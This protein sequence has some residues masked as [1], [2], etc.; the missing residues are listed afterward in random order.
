[1]GRGRGV[2]S[3][4]LPAPPPKFLDTS[5]MK[6]VLHIPVTCSL[7]CLCRHVLRTAAGRLLASQVTQQEGPLPTGAVGTISPASSHM[8]WGGATRLPSVLLS[9]HYEPT[10]TESRSSQQGRAGQGRGPCASTENT[11]GTTAT[12]L[13]AALFSSLFC[14]R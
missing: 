1:M 4:S 9:P 12:G 7:R 5:L 14:A 6:T 11:Q 3:L 10:S 13:S 2:A 8:L